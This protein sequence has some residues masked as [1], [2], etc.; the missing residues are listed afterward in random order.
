MALPFEVRTE[1]ELSDVRQLRPV[2][3]RGVGWDEETVEVVVST[4][5]CSI[6][7]FCRN[8]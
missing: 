7:S 4:F 8:V 1:S 5:V 3:A 6:F 2:Y